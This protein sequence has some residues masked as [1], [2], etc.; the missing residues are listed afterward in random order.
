MPFSRLQT[1]HLEAGFNERQGRDA[2]GGAQA[3][4]DHVSLLQLNRHCPSPVWRI[5]QRR[6]PICV[7]AWRPDPFAAAKR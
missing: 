7:S 4:D 6:R 2:A 3:D 5:R 1:D